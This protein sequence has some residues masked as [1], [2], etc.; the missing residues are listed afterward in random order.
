M[1]KNNKN[2]HIE[3]CNY[4]HK[5]IR[6]NIQIIFNYI[7]NILEI[8]LDCNDADVVIEKTFLNILDAYKSG[9]LEKETR[10]LMQ[11]EYFLDKC[12]T[13]KNENK[14]RKYKK[15]LYRSMVIIDL[16]NLYV[17]EFETK[18]KIYSII[19]INSNVLKR[20]VSENFKLFNKFDLNVDVCEIARI[21][22]ELDIFQPHNSTIKKKYYPTIIVDTVFFIIFSSIQDKI[23]QI[24][25]N[26][27][28]IC[29]NKPKKNFFKSNLDESI[30]VN[31]YSGYKRLFDD[32][33]N[34]NGQTTPST[35]IDRQSFNKIIQEHVENYIKYMYYYVPVELNCA[36][37]TKSD[38][39]KNKAI[40][41]QYLNR[42]CKAY[43]AVSK[44]HYY[45][46]LNDENYNYMKKNFLFSLPYIKSILRP[47]YSAQARKME[48]YEAK[49]LF[50]QQKKM[51]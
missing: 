16:Y 19:R 21:L 14:S 33:S 15:I 6:N 24:E 13:T 10:F 18:M 44:K 20:M 35:T 4:N 17:Q 25:K 50:E 26:K 42:T 31:L 48:R 23:I 34:Y 27:F 41:L 29:K 40:I 1:E 36:L 47:I 5:R 12:T 51:K 11:C 49:R 8:V 39:A 32:F 28:Q 37:I 38:K 7:R 43:D 2:P 30:I 46:E 9:M 3:V 22:K 45:V